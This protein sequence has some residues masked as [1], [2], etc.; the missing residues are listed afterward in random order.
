MG[1]YFCHWIIPRNDVVAFAFCGETFHGILV[2]QF[3]C[4]TD[5]YLLMSVKTGPKRRSLAIRIG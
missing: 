5:N 3:Q 1:I 2:P 4:I